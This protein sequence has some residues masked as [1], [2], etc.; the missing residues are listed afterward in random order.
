[1]L[2]ICKYFILEKCPSSAN[3]MVR[4]KGCIIVEKLSFRKKYIY[5][6]WIIQIIIWSHEWLVDGW[7]NKKTLKYC[8]SLNN[9]DVSKDI[10]LSYKI[11]F[12]YLLINTNKQGKCEYFLFLFNI[13]SNKISFKKLFFIS[14]GTFISKFYS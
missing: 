8:Y 10:S 5:L 4:L 14:L 1:M 9:S 11:K 7:Y 13:W 3:L 2:V 12:T 6:L